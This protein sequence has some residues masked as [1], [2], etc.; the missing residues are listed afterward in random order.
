MP[1]SSL[2][3]LA[4]PAEDRTH[5]Q[6]DVAFK[7]V[8]ASRRLRAR[9]T[10]RLK[11]HDQTEA[12]WSA[13][14]MLADAPSGLIQTELAERMGVEGPTLV[15]LLDAL[16]AQGLISRRASQYDRR[17]KTLFIEPAGRATIS[18]IDHVASDLRNELFDGVSDGDLAST[19]RVL[20]LLAER[21]ERKH[22]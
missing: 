22:G 4:A 12:R 17:A 3:V 9:F 19:L 7:L 6:Y 2:K 13:L 8:L 1:Q 5:L 14:Y 21:L 11:S 16:E 20:N 10:D 18:Q 15:R